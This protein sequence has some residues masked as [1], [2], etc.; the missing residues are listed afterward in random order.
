MPILSS[1][2]ARH[3]KSYWSGCIKVAMIVPCQQI[4]SIVAPFIF[5]SGFI[6]KF[7]KIVLFL[8]GRRDPVAQLQFLII[9]SLCK[10]FCV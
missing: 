9:A 8:L 7:L 3:R 6:K 2:A 5:L 10:S 4:F 1:F